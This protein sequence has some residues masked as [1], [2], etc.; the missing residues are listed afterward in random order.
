MIALMHLLECGCGDIVQKNGDESEEKDGG[1]YEREEK[2]AKEMRMMA[3]VLRNL[4]YN[5]VLC[6]SPTF[7]R[8]M[9]AVFDTETFRFFLLSCQCFNKT[10]MVI[11]TGAQPRA[12]ISALA[13]GMVISM[14][15]SMT[16]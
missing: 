4:I 7:L 16:S 9:P 3:D 1:K 12:I 6:R 14:C 13:N 15:G 11:W 2:V 5:E 10:G 8:M